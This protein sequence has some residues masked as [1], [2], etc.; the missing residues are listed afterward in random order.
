MA[1]HRRPPGQ[2]AV[3]CACGCGRYAKVGTYCPGHWY[4]V[5][6]HL[7]SDK[8]QEELW[9]GAESKEYDALVA[10]GQQPRWSPEKALMEA[11][12]GEVLSHRSRRD[13]CAR[14]RFC[15]RCQEDQAWVLSEEDEYIYSFESIC[16]H[17]GIA[18]S[19][20]RERLFNNAPLPCLRNHERI[21]RRAEIR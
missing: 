17:L 19:K 8:S 14:K 3:L 12:L 13:R 10:L 18:A 1:S 11:M 6:G 20:L 4:R 7:R 9:R 21:G 16:F 5:P 2:P 15:L